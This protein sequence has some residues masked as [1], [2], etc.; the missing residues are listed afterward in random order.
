MNE[1]NEQEQPDRSAAAAGQQKSHSS[2]EN[3]V[4]VRQEAAEQVDFNN[5]AV[6][7]PALA[8][9]AGA[10]HDEGKRKKNEENKKTY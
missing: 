6:A 7:A 3:T 2:A 9:E 4:P 8:G 1:S 10:G 5:P